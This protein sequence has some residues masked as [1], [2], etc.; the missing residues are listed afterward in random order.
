LR[1]S[2]MRQGVRR[3]NRSATAE[4]AVLNDHISELLDRLPFLATIRQ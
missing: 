3:T 4:A 2:A 1:V